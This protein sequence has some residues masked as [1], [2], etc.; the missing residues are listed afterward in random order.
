MEA[1]GWGLDPEH[2]APDVPQTWR[3]SNNE[4]G[5]NDEKAEMLL[6]LFNPHLDKEPN[7]KYQ[8]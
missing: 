6:P 5:E 8:L 1:K 3:Q 4:H 7:Q 2:Q